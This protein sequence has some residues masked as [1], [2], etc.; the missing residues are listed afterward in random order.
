[1]VYLIGL[2]FVIAMFW[3]MVIAIQSDQIG[4]AIGIFFI[5]ILFVP[6]YGLLNLDKAK[7]PFFLTVGGFLLTLVA[8]ASG[9]V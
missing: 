2:L 3:M 5:P 4:W 1:M 9:L 6:L 8:G 7:T